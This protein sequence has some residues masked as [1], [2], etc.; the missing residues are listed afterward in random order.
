[1]NIY[2]EAQRLDTI[3]NSS[4]HIHEYRVVSNVLACRLEREKVNIATEIQYSAAVLLLA[5]T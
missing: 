4:M 5:G 3:L 1:M 2:G